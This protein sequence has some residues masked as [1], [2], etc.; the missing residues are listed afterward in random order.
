ML[1]TKLDAH[2]V[3]GRILEEALHGERAVR[4]KAG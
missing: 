4:N 3:N 2:A 1:P